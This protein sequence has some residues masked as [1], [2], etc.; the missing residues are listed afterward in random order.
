[1]QCIKKTKELLFKIIPPYG[2]AALAVICVLNLTVFYGTRP[3][4]DPLPHYDLTTPLDRMIPFVPAFIL[5]YFIVAYGQ[6]ALGF[7][8]AAREDKK[9][10]TLIF[11]AEIIAKLFCLII[12]FALPTTMERGVIAGGD[13]FSRL[14]AW[15]YSIDTPT[16]L[17]PSIHCLESYLLWRTLPLVKGAPKWYRILT[18]FVTLLVFASVLLVKQHVFL[19]VLGGIAVVEIGLI[20]MKYIQKRVKS[21]DRVKCE[22]LR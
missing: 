13:I 10:V 11:G 16:N 21:F 2:C 14:V 12:F 8:L 7:L 18:P 9:T 6:W 15:L 1:M 3:F 17:F 22:E 5:V 19:D 4:T 20:L